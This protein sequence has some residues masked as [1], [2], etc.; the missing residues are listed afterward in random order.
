MA[1]CIHKRIALKPKSPDLS[2][3]HLWKTVAYTFPTVS[4]KSLNC[5]G[6]VGKFLWLKFVLTPS[7]WDEAA[8]ISVSFRW[9][10]SSGG[11][12]S[13]GQRSERCSFTQLP[14]PPP[15]SRMSFSVFVLAAADGE[16][17]QRAGGHAADAPFAGR[18]S[19]RT[20][21]H[22]GGCCTLDVC[23][24]PLPDPPSS[25]G[26]LKQPLAAPASV[27]S[28]PPPPPRCSTDLG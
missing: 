22:G 6:N 23:H 10:R 9:S 15:W 20:A 3:P 26:T 7:G 21:V 4:V 12:R 1:S 25:A 18:S 16:R 13:R 27:S 8:E 14:S 17:S 19:C 28:P 24:C 11:V 5:Q 2:F